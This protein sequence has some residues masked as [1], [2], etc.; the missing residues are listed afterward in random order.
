MR[1]LRTKE[2]SPNV[3]EDTTS[4]GYELDIGTGSGFSGFTG[5]WVRRST[6]VLASKSF[7][8]AYGRE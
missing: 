1:P 6:L 7:E 3:C 2:M 8:T 4:D 5:T